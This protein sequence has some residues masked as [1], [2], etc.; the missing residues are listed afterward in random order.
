MLALGAATGAH[1]Q[2][3]AADK[4]NDNS[5]VLPI[6]DNTSGKLQAYLLLEPTSKSQTGARWHF[7]GNTLDAAIG[8]DAGDSL[9]LLCDRRNG[10]TSAVGSLAASNC[11]LATLNDDGSRRTSAT[12]AIGR[13]GGR[14]G[15]TAGTGRDTLPAWLSGGRGAAQVDVNDL[16]VFAQKNI[17]SETVVQIAGTIAKARILSPAEA[18]NFGISDQWSTRT[19]SIGGGYGAFSANIIGRVVD[20]PGQPKFEGLG[21][22]LTWR[23]P[24]SGQLTVGADNLVTRGKNPFSP[25][26]DSKQDEGAVP[27]VRYEQDL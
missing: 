22:G 12:A 15:L 19:L 20:T 1:A 16:T 23:T 9:G 18:S 13:D 7:G 3:K 10:L 26:T 4:R 2:E 27:Y 21:L 25:S 5:A 17:G 24:W 6:W 8:L 14:L 11:M